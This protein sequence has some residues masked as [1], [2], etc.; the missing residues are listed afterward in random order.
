M[1]LC[2]KLHEVVW[3]WYLLNV[4]STGKYNTR[5]FLMW[6]RVQQ[7][8]KCLRPCQHS[9]KKEHQAINLSPPRRVRVWGDDLLRL[10]RVTW[11]LGFP[12]THIRQPRLSNH[13][14]K[15]FMQ[16]TCPCGLEHTHTHTHT[17]VCDWLSRQDSWPCWLRSLLVNTCTIW[18]IREVTTLCVT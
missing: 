7:L 18:Q 5:P 3:D 16:S 6:F 10:G 17:H 14:L 11:M 12:D 2:V 1:L 8:Q 9:S 13:R 4:P 15:T